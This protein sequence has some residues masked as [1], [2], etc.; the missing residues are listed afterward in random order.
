MQASNL[1]RDSTSRDDDECD[2]TQLES[3]EDL[4]D[5]F[6]VTASLLI[7]CTGLLIAAVWFASSPNFEKC[8]ALENV[9][10][11]NVCYDALKNELFKPPAKGADLKIGQ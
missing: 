8:S 7:L 5:R 1:H 11:R 4:V 9:A 3:P 6:G 10:E 2:A